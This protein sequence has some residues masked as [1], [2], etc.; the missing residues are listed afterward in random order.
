MSSFLKNIFSSCSC[1][2]ATQAQHDTRLKGRTWHREIASGRLLRVDFQELERIVCERLQL[3]VPLQ[4]DGVDHLVPPPHFK[5]E[6]RKD[7]C[8]REHRRE[9][10]IYVRIYTDTHT[11]THGALC[12]FP[13][14]SNRAETPPASRTH[15]ARSHNLRCRPPE[16]GARLPGRTAAQEMSALRRSQQVSVRRLRLRW[17]GP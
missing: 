10:Y 13:S 3:L 2:F 8:L 14:L 12:S 16:Q 1:S 9:V 5:V 15:S 6:Q 7:V 4:V 11:D 17:P